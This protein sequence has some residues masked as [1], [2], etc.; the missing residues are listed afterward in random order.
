[1]HLKSSKVSTNADATVKGAQTYCI[2]NKWDQLAAKDCNRK[3]YY[4]HKLEK[5]F[6]YV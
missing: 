2:I 6:L 4:R 1:M 3:L 5:L